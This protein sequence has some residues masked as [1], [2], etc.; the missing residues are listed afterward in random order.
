MV[1]IFLFAGGIAYAAGTHDEQGGS[2]PA[3]APDNSKIN[4]RDE[5][6]T[7]KTAEKQSNEPGDVELT[8]KI[9]KEITS[10][11]SLSVL[12][13]NVKIITQEGKVSLR[14]PVNSPEEKNNI[15]KK[16]E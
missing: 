1:A 3:V 10:D 2:P 5:H 6:P 8:R 16:A 13:K 14:G 12:A 11:D 7:S 4:T 9:R 15:S